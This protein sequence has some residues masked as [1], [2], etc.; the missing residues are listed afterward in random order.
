M[1]IYVFPSHRESFGNVLLEAMAMQLPIVSVNAGGVTD[2]ITCGENALCVRPQQAEEIFGALQTL[3][4]DNELSAQM[5]LKARK[6]A[7]DFS[8][9]KFLNNLVTEYQDV[10]AKK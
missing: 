10:I 7:L 4:N 6:R 9:E 3:L 8:S 5:A 1:D 2:M